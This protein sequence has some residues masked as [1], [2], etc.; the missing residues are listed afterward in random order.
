MRRRTNGQPID[1]ASAWSC[2]SSRTY[3]SGKRIGDRR[4][5]LR[6]LHQR[7]LEAAQ[8][9]CQVLRVLTLVQVD[10]QKP[11]AGQPGR[12]PADRRPDPRIA[13]HAAADRI[14]VLTRHSELNRPRTRL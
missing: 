6:H 9:R 5:Q 8:R 12:E 1:G 2:L 10:A 13:T 11:R 14:V 7:P 3:S 4:H